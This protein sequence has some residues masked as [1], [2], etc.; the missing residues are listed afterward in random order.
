VPLNILKK[1]TNAVKAGAFQK[2]CGEKPAHWF[3]QVSLDVPLAFDV[4]NRI[5]V[6]ISSR[7][8]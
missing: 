8:D 1:N 5:G 4:N 2:Y 7:K 6:K 3:I